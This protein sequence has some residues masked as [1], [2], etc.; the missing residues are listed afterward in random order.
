MQVGELSS[1]LLYSVTL[2]LICQTDVFEMVSAEQ[3]AF[4][5]SKLRI[6]Y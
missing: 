1:Y 5:H 4:T 6:K 3:L 2:S